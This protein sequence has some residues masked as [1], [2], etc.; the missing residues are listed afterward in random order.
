MFSLYLN[1]KRHP[2]W[3]DLCIVHKKRIFGE[4]DGERGG[5]VIACALRTTVVYLVLIAA[6][7]LLGKRQLGQLEPSEFVVAM[8]VADLASVPMQNSGIPLLAG[9]LLSRVVKLFGLPA[10]TAYLIDGSYNPFLY[11]RF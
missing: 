8:L 10:V 5:F 3:G 2:P 6:M 11:F 9:L 4:T 1:R 7:R